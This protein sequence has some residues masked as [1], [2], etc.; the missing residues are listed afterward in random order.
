[1]TKGGGDKTTDEAQDEKISKQFNGVVIP[2]GILM[3]EPDGHHRDLCERRA[4]GRARGPYD[5][6]LDQRELE[7]RRALRQS[8]V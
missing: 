1:M 3:Q 7:G 6:H 5:W 4:Q 2:A 8:D